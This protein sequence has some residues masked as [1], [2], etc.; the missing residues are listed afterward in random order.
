M[1]PRKRLLTVRRRDQ[2]GAAHKD[3]LLLEEPL[4]LTLQGGG[5]RLRLATILRTPGHDY[6]LVLGYLCAL[7]LIH[8]PED[9]KELDY[10]ATPQDF[11][12]LTVIFRGAIPEKALQ[13]RSQEWVHGGCGACGQDS[14]AVTPPH[15][16]VPVPP[17]QPDWL[18]A[19]PE[20]LR[21]HQDLFEKCGGSHAAALVRPGG[22]PELVYEDVG[23]HNAVDKVTGRL[24][25]EKKSAEGNWLLLSGRSGFELVQKAVQARFSAVASV[26]PPSS[27]ALNYASQA[28]LTLVGFLR[29]DRYNV[30]TERLPS[31]SI[32][33]V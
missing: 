25:M 28:G 1:L 9:V 3:Q 22:Q 2:A 26:G 5:R 4:Q 7:G 11:N 8:S 19:L 31:S 32:S 21:R 13:L 10:C 15:Q 18:C 24:F 16:V 12:H 29:G 14:L 30:Y 17:W 20:Q 27:L 23:R 33:A 6:E